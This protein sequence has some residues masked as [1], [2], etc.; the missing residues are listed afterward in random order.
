MDTHHTSTLIGPF[1]TQ[2]QAQTAAD[3]AM[4]K[5]HMRRGSAIRGESRLVQLFELGSRCWLEL[6]E[7][8]RAVARLLGE[9][10]KLDAYR[11][12]IENRFDDECHGGELC[13]LALKGTRIE[14]VEEEAFEAEDL[15]RGG[16]LHEVG[17]YYLV[18]FVADAHGFERP[19]GEPPEPIATLSYGPVEM[20]GSAMVVRARRAL[21]DANEWKSK[22]VDG[23]WE[24]QITVADG[25]RRILWLSQAEWDE[26]GSSI[27]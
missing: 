5:V 26:L 24:L 2:E 25:S 16:V 3:A 19:R 20:V 8:D 22:Q 21:A 10:A 13:R 27:E 11:C 4:A 15:V 1:A 12:R 17:L 6:E 18:E 7:D 9:D 23:K 14:V